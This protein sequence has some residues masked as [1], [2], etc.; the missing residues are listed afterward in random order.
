M[1]GTDGPFTWTYIPWKEQIR[2]IKEP[3]KEILEKA[4]VEFS[5]EEIYNV[6]RGNALRFLRLK[7]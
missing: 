5:D 4:N 1:F 7:K 2:I 3:D 6:L